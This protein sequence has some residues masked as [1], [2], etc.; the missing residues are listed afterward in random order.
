MMVQISKAMG[1]P[2][3]I[4]VE[5]IFGDFEH[6]F[7]R[8]ARIFVGYSGGLDSTVL[9]HLTCK[10]AKAGRVTALHV[11]HGLSSDADLWEQHAER[12]SDE[13]SANFEAHRVSCQARSN[14]EAL[15]RDARYGVFEKTLAE[16]DILLL[17]HHADDQAET[18]LYNLLR[19][20]GS[21]GMSGIPVMR[22]LGLGR[23]LRPLLGRTKAQIKSY[24]TRHRLKWIED[25]SN[26]DTS[27][28]RNY[29]RHRILPL[30]AK[31]W[32]GHQNRIAITASQSKN[33]KSLAK[34]IFLNDLA[35]LDFRNDRAGISFCAKRMSLLEAI[36]QKNIIRQL[37]GE[38]K[39]SL[40]ST[41]VIDE[42]FDVL[43]N[44]RSDASPEVKA[45]RCVFR[46]YRNRVY[47][48]R[49]GKRNSICAKNCITWELKKML[50]L[51][52]GGSVVAE[53]ID[54]QGIRLG[55][56]TSLEIRFRLGGE[57]CRPSG[58]RH[59]QT[60]K[61]L[62]QEY[63]LEPWWRSSIPLFFLHNELVA[64]GDLWVCEGWETEKGEKGL[65][66]HWQVNSL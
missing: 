47:L 37:P 18:V 28:D 2:I 17:A 33:D 53:S 9:L 25:E 5:N 55:E 8:S 46:R 61:K 16:D 26:L 45:D 35:K 24:A 15:A 62:F 27:F 20:S 32:A 51:P 31:R 59:S 22:D 7:N 66:I 40:P 64:V 13:L 65:K 36:R 48:L 3:E 23:L 57:R 50:V 38:L 21:T 41:R 10:Y 4:E 39:L 44:A 63:A 34:S 54:S 12:Q 52:G 60:L 19:G 58:R 49:V 11:N 42:V 56:V 14:T 43:L 1:V 29:L 30:I 6:L